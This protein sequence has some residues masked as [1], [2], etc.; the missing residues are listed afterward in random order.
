MRYI[1]IDSM[2]MFFRMRHSAHRGASI[3]DKLGLSMHMMFAS[4]NKVVMNHNVDHVVFCLEG[5]NNWRK[6]FYEPYKKPRAEQRQQ[7]S[8]SEIEEDE[9]FFEVFNEFAK[10]IHE[11]TNCS[12]IAAPGAEADDVIARWIAMHPEDEHVI[13][14][15]DTDYYQLLTD[16]V[17]QFNGITGHLITLDGVFDDRNKPVINKKTNE[18]TTIETPDWILFEKCM[19]G[20]KS[21]NVFSAY[22]GVR[23]KGTKSK[24][25]L[26]E[27]YADRDKKGYN[28]N[29]LMLQKWV[30]HNDREHRVL[31]D[32]ERNRVLIDL[33]MQPQE[34]KDAVDTAII[35]TLL[36]EITT[37]NH[38][39]SFHFMKFCAKHSLI[40]LSERPVDVVSWLVKPYTG[41]ILQ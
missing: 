8:E 20:D 30:D 29:N 24:T 26:R 18:P 31:D 9:L 39:V 12:V 6:R 38:K 15:S 22:P 25:G 14:S 40:K 34:I 37:P 19:R 1:L 13:L 23:T 10:Y 3:E 17:T 32:Y 2:N 36:D 11:Y 16:K 33:T 35:T 7:R 21:D 5:G 28:W 27:A 4:T 41:H